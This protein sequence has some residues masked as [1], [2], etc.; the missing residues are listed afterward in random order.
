MSYVDQ[1]LMSGEQ[2]A[3]RARL[4][5]MVFAWPAMWLLLGVLL[6][7]RPV[8]RG[9]SDVSPGF[10]DLA[11]ILLV[12]AV[13]T[14]VGALVNFTTSEFA[15][16]TKRILMKTGLIRRHTIEVLLTQVEGVQV[17]QGILGRLLDYGT[18][19]VTGTGGSHEPI[20][21][22]AAPLKF[23]Q[24]VHE[25]VALVQD[26]RRWAEGIAAPGSVAG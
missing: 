14:G 22:I 1:N 6:L 17:H 24:K 3:G 18:V 26:F 23:R 10:V 2:V 9:P 16:T 12:L 25:Q 20:H 13:V 19:I 21:R 4:H 15:V 8:G 5:W 11:S 7:A